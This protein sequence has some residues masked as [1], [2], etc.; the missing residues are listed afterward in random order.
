M[1]T[2]LAAHAN[3]ES[4]I[5]VFAID[6]AYNQLLYVPY[7]TGQGENGSVIR[8]PTTVTTP[9]FSGTST[10]SMSEIYVQPGRT[11]SEDWTVTYQDGAWYLRGTRSGPISKAA[12]PGVYYTSPDGSL[13]F[14]IEGFAN[15][16]DQFT[17]STNNG[18]EETNLS[19]TPTA[20]TMAPDGSRLALIVDDNQGAKVE[21]YDPANLSF[22]TSTNFGQVVQPNRMSWSE[23][24][25]TLWVADVLN[26][27]VWAI[28]RRS[29]EVAT[30]HNLP[31]PV[32]DVTELNGE[33][34]HNL[35]LTSVGEQA[36]W[37]Y[38]P[39][40]ESLVDLNPWTEAV[41]GHWFPSPI[42][43]IEAMLHPIGF[44]KPMKTRCID[45][46]VRLRLV[47]T[48]AVWSFS[49]RRPDVWFET[50][51]VQEPNYRARL[52][53]L[54]ITRRTLRGPVARR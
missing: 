50:R 48:P 39:V 11:A 19:G 32:S 20:I 28:D 1:L 3:D 51:T 27:I 17:F 36:V 42:M 26:P 46:D 7:M 35:Y 53:C 34:G 49:M 33:F 6:K 30:P 10:P 13:G 29:P 15:E 40:A 41:D 12:L 37:V 5:G 4:H 23:D 14:V 45:L 25:E 47:C 16:G 21:W 38:D 2:G 18:I 31:W 22:V 43:G 9:E 54:M 24:G 8:P 52:A 44:P